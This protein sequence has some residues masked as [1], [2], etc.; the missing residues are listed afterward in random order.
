[1]Q[2]KINLF[3]KEENHYLTM[4]DKVKLK[5]IKNEEM[6]N[7]KHSL[8]NESYENSVI[9]E[10]EIDVDLNLHENNSYKDRQ[11]SILLN[12][13]EISYSKKFYKELI[14]D[15][16]EQED[17]LY[18]NSLL[19]FKIKNIK[20]KCL[21]KLLMNEYNNYLQMK[22]K[23]FHELDEIIHKIKNEF[24]KSSILL[25]KTDS[26]VYEMTTQ[27]YCKFLYLLSK[28]S[29]KKEN[30]IKR[31][32]YITLGINMLKIFFIRKKYASNI[33]TY[34]IYC[35][36]LL[37]LINSLIGDNNYEQALYYSRL[38]FQIIEISMKI[39][40]YN[41]SK[42]NKEK[43]PDRTIKKFITFGAIAY[44]YI[45]CCLEHLDDPIQAFE[46]YK[47]AKFFF[48]KTLGFSFQKFNNTISI[49]N[50]TSFLAEESFEKL[51]LKII[52][53]KLDSLNR[54]KILEL[55]KKKEEMKLLQKEKLIR[56]KFIANGIG[57][58]PFKVEKLENKLN[59]K[60]F[61]SSA[62]DNLE[63]IDNELSSLVFTLFNRNKQN[64]ISTNKHKVSQNTKKIMSRYELYNILMSKKFRGFIMQNKKLQFYNP[65]TTSDSISIIH[66]HLNKK[67]KIESNS[68]SMNS[69]NLFKLTNLTNDDNEKKIIKKKISY[70]KRKAS[71]YKLSKYNNFKFTLTRDKD[72]PNER[73]TKIYPSFTLNMTKSKSNKNF[74]YK[75]K[76][77]FNE[78]EIDFE[79]K[80]LDKIFMTKNYL[81]KY[82]YYDKLSDK[83]LKYQKELLYLKSDNNLYN[84]RN[85]TEEKNG[86]LDK[87]DLINLSL[88]VNERAKEKAKISTEE[89][90][91]DID[92]LKDSF[93]TKQ[94]KV[95][96]KMKS[97][98]SSVISKYINERKSL[99]EKENLLKIVKIKTNNEKKL[100][101]LD[102]SINIINKNISK[103]KY[104]M[105][106]HK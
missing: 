70:F 33:K 64:N 85:N 90:L 60:N 38:L 95:S 106:K 48:R 22:N 26:Y 74:T 17:L 8:T 25:I 53:D 35:K 104:F 84:S 58:D 12:D 87:G 78:L 83:E 51:K 80:N 6:N 7:S 56:L 101:Y 103:V 15:I 20:I 11:L 97:A 65:K 44:I 23:T 5:K 41:N 92:L 19:S 42:K 47:Q 63:N 43:I 10:E 93:G 88:I 79:K 72:E 94:N 102:N 62:I 39:I 99:T 13:F 52:K 67:I 96:L 73:K 89:N 59:K 14:I 34:I 49:T 46:A 32:G 54:Q 28:I 24:H 36:L 66:S 100:L 61:L 76:K 45:G 98:M 2:D 68:K 55:Q 71:K 27:I 18:Q 57:E 77:K 3:N 9:K 1:M 105:R 82:S 86:I 30:Y 16:E 91:I 69:R 29:L 31:L 75:L 21:L 40:Y 81:R 50:S 4:H 37:E